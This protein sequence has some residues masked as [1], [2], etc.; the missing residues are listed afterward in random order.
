MRALMIITMGA[1]VMAEEPHTA[2]KK[3]ISIATHD[4]VYYLQALMISKP[5]DLRYMSSITLMQSSPELQA[6]ANYNNC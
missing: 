4:I 3:V 1:M 6:A 5:H 2:R